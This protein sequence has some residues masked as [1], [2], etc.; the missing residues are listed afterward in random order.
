M[1]GNTQQISYFPWSLENSID[2]DH[3]DVQQMTHF[4]INL[5]KQIPI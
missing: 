5:Y 2:M 3:L 1:K 4:Y